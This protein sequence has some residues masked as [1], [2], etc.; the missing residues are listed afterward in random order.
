MRTEDIKHTDVFGFGH[1]CIDYLALLDPFPE[2]GKKGDVVE[3]RV[4]G[5]GPVPTALLT[6]VKF[7]LTAAFCGKVGD[8]RDGRQVIEELRAGGVDVSP[9]IIDKTAA[10][11]RAFIWIDAC[12]GSRSVALDKTGLTWATAEELDENPISGCRL[13]F[14]DGRAVEACL[15]G[16]KLAR[17][18]GVRTI[19]DTGAVRPRFV[20]ILRLTDY[21]VV[22]SDLADTLSPGDRP[23]ELAKLLV[24]MGANT[25][26]VTAGEEGAFWFD[27]SI[28]GHVR[29]F[30]VDAVDTT[31]AGDVFHG[32]FIYALLQ[33]SDLIEA[34]SFAN[35][36]AAL[37]CRRLSGRLGIP[38]LAEVE[39]LLRMS[40]QNDNPV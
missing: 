18:S 33:G 24:R 11:A 32:G 26:V 12:D 2:K 4:I 40:D 14:C 3:S 10:T 23:E 9:M 25:A 36:A 37:S 29:G 16:L 13:F 15:K 30:S 5:G 28:G 34:I 39:A 27:G 17:E 31:G 19:L 7:G 8:D 20:E 38:E 21:A 1:C 22:S 35:A 6:V